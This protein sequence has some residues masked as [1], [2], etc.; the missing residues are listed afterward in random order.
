MSGPLIGVLGVGGLLALIFAR[1]PVGVALGIAGIVGYAALDGWHRALLVLG[2]TPYDLAAA[3]SLSVLPLFILMGAVAS[4]SGMARELFQAANALFSGRRGTL[5]MATIGAC[6]GMGSISGSSLAVTATMSRVVVPEMRAGRLRRPARD[7]GGGLG[8]HARHPDPALGDAGDLCDQRRAVGAAA[9][10]GR[11]DPGRAAGCLP[12][13]G[14]RRDRAA[15]ARLGAGERA[16]AVA[17]AARRAARH[18]EARAD[19]LLRGRRHL[20]RL[21][22]SDRGRRDGRVRDDRDRRA[23]RSIRPAGAAR[24]PRRDR[25][26]VRD[27]VLHP[28]GRASVRLFPGAGAPAGSA[29]RV[30]AGTGRPAA[31]GDADHGRV[32]RRARLLSRI[33]SRCS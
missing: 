4:H 10:R 33:R 11:P 14:G 19:L 28:P 21:V 2:Q 29:G 15:A 12:G 24:L 25:A 22:Q 31:R 20:H 8:R 17:R 27:A 32:L 7:R 16:R 26:H 1:V 9:V 13:P 6:A 30:R 5:A 3:Y 18:V 23:R